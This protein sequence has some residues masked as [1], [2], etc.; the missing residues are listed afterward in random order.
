P[1][2]TSTMLLPSNVAVW[3]CDGGEG[4]DGVAVQV[5]VPLKS[6]ADD[7]V[8]EPLFPPATSTVPL[9]TIDCGSTVALCPN[10]AAVIVPAVDHEPFETLGSKT[11]A[12]ARTVEPFLPPVTKIFPSVLGRTLAVC[13]SRGPLIDASVEN[14]FWTGS[15]K[16]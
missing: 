1:P 2:A 4:S 6:S 14:A 8:A 13:C 7:S 16:N 12:V 9:A 10:R 15:Y 3:P 11:S 5:L